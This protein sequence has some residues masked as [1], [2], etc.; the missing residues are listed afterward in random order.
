MYQGGTG[1]ANAYKTNVEIT[2]DNK[3]LAIG[4]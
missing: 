4:Y 3:R 2:K 1:G